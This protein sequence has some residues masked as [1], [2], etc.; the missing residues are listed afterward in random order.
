MIFHCAPAFHPRMYSRYSHPLEF[1][2]VAA[3]FPTLTMI[4]GHA[5]GEWWADCVAVA[6]GHPNMILELSEWHTL[7]R[8][9]PQEA[10]HAIDRMR[11]AVGI[12]HIVWAT[13]FPGKRSFISM[14]ECVEI[15]QSFP[16]LGAKYGYKFSEND[17]EAM[18]GGNAAH[19][20]KLSQD[21]SH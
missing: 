18:L 13:D 7:I 16:S 3:D 5:G 4:M 6:Q 20:L 15:F 2:D 11:N 14:K 10:L 21:L 1:D 17:V 8:D 12:D 9:R 19:L